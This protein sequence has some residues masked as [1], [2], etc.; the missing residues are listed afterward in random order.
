MDFMSCIL[1]KRKKITAVKQR[2]V[3]ILLH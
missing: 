2:H 1:F 3:F